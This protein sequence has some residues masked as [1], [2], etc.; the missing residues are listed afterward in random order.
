M[1]KAIDAIVCGVGS[2]VR[3]R[4]DAILSRRAPDLEFVL[5]PPARGGDM[6]ARSRSG[7]MLWRDRETSFH[8]SPTFRRSSSLYNPD[9]E[10]SGPRA[11]AAHRDPRGS[12]TE[13]ARAALLSVANRRLQRVVTFVCDTGRA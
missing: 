4:A 10:S 12:S 6:S 7:I 3:S 1:E 11:C 2:A 5:D 9:E 13:R 8:P